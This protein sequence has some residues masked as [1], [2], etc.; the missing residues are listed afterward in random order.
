MET[1]TYNG[2]DHPHYELMM[3]FFNE[4]DNHKMFKGCFDQED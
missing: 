4:I 1:N 2:L 3:S